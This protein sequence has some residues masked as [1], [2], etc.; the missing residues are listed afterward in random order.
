MDIAEDVKAIPEDAYAVAS[1]AVSAALRDDRCGVSV[2]FGMVGDTGAAFLEHVARAI[3]AERERCAKVAEEHGA[4]VS[5]EP[6]G[7]ACS[8]NIA[9]SIRSGART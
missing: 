3:L 4:T 1:L 7:Q 8:R 5:N 6:I 9:S 2:R